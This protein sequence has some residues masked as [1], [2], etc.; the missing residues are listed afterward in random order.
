MPAEATATKPAS[1]PAIESGWTRLEAPELFSF[2]KP[3]EQFA[4]VLTNITTIDLKGKRIP[5]YLFARDSKVIKMLGTYD[6][7]QKLTRRYVGNMVRITYL[8]EDQS[9]SRNG[10]SMKVFDVQIKGTPSE[11]PPA[12]PFIASDEDIPF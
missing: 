6:L 7:V 9:V 2:E 8:G 5:Q 10:N 3:G 4:G 11:Q 12:A 1:P